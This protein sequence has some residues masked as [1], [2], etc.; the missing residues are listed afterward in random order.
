MVQIQCK[1]TAATARNPSD[2]SVASFWEEHGLAKNAIANLKGL[3]S[4]LSCFLLLSNRQENKDK[5]KPEGPEDD[6][7]PS[8]EEVKEARDKDYSFLKH[9][10]ESHTDYCGAVWDDKARLLRKF[11]Y[12]FSLFLEAEAAGQKH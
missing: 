1:H 2:V 12:P 6:Y 3:K 9:R 10:V 7:E 8:Q 11:F 5:N 4:P